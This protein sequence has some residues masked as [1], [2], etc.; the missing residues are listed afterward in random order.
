MCV[1]LLSIFYV[2]FLFFLGIMPDPGGEDSKW[3]KE[4]SLFTFLVKC[5]RYQ[6]TERGSTSVA[7]GEE[8]G[9]QQGLCTQLSSR[10]CAAHNSRGSDHKP[11]HKS[12]PSGGEFSPLQWERTLVEGWHDEH[13][14]LW[15]FWQDAALMWYVP[16][17]LDGLR[18]WSGFG[19]WISSN[20]VVGIRHPSSC[21]RK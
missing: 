15:Q 6:G 13:L 2:P 8:D 9:R 7:W 18:S 10:W 19:E 3:N 17:G 5:R 11:S 1:V 14:R 4:E 16:W 20:M 21:R 12:A